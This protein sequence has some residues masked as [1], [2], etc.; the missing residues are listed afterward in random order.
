MTLIIC[1]KKKLSSELND[2]FDKSAKHLPKQIFR[3]VNREYSTSSID[4][5]LFKILTMLSMQ[6]PVKYP[7]LRAK[8]KKVEK[9]KIIH[10]L[11][12]KPE[13][14]LDD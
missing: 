13:G 2:K 4:Y 8:E 14:G 11:V 3:E 9:G 12:G 7:Q 1:A 6:K 10:I 5:F